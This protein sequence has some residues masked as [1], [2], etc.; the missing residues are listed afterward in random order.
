MFYM[1]RGY[2]DSG[3]S[4]FFVTAGLLQDWEAAITLEKRREW[5][6]GS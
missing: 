2:L 6:A 3:W 1:F 5:K 4:N